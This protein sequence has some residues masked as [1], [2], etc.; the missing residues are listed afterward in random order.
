MRGRERLANVTREENDAAR[1]MFQ[2]AIDLDS[3]YAAAYAALGGTYFDAA[4]SGW[5]E[6]PDQDVERA[7]KLA[8]KA[9]TLNPATTSAYRLLAVV[10]LFG[11]HY[12]LALAQINRALEINP[13]D[14]DSYVYRGVILVFAGDLLRPCH[15][16]K[17]RCVSTAPTSCG[18]LPRHGLLFPG[19]LS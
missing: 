12:D 2:R 1:D 4:V 14:L 9:L 17:K 11:R 15:G 13:S 16:L 18:S 10:H 19:A 8:Q 3:N 7:A 6:F 5:T